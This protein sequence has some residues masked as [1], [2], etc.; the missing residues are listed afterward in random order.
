M[1]TRETTGPRP[2]ASEQWLAVSC[3]APSTSLQSIAETCIIGGYDEAIAPQHEYLAL[4]MLVVAGRELVVGPKL[5]LGVIISGRRRFRTSAGGKDSRTIS[6]GWC[7]SVA[8]V[9]TSAS[10]RVW[11]PMMIVRDFATARENRSCLPGTRSDSGVRDSS[12]G[13]SRHARHADRVF[14]V[15]RFAR[16]VILR[17][18]DIWGCGS[19]TFAEPVRASRSSR[20]FHPHVPSF[21]HPCSSRFIAKTRQ[22]RQRRHLHHHH[23]C[24]PQPPSLPAVPASPSPGARSHFHLKEAATSEVGNCPA[25]SAVFLDAHIWHLTPPRLISSKLWI[26]VL[27]SRN[28][29]SPACLDESVVTFHFPPTQ[30]MAAANI[31]QRLH[32]AGILHLYLR[33][34]LDHMPLQNFIMS[35]TG[36]HLLLQ[37]S[38]RHSSMDSAH[39]LHMQTLRTR[40]LRDSCQSINNS[41]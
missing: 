8:R 2:A 11:R 40:C 13:H 18:K 30:W 7:R 37:C 39:L 6:Y 15:P 20:C 36:R 3:F 26:S 41:T 4:S 14:E 22:Q 33:T 5:M 16:A 21:F 24:F 31:R 35:E 38:R 25:A 28:T 17:L 19:V 34:T 27:L 29:R 32:Q 23:H 10:K 12:I 1:L 9:Y